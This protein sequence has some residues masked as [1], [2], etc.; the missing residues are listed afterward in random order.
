[1]QTAPVRWLASSTSML[2]VRP[3]AC[4]SSTAGTAAGPSVLR[5]A[6]LPNAAVSLR[7][8]PTA[9]R[10]SS[11]AYIPA[12]SDAWPPS[13]DATTVFNTVSMFVEET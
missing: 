4:R 2:P 13:T 1:V 7:L 12:R 5:S 6:T 9:R 8:C 11:I 10:A 3:A